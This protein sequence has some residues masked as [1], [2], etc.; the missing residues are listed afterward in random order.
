[1]NAPQRT[2]AYAPGHDAVMRLRIVAT[3]AV[4]GVGFRPFVHRLAVSEGL[5][6]FVRNTGDGAVI[7]VE[8]DALALERFVARFDTEL[9]HPAQV[10]ERRIE[11]MAACGDEAFAIAAST[12]ERTQF[13]AVLPDLATCAECLDEI[14]D[15]S[16]RRYRYPFTTCVHCGPRFSL[17]ECAPYDR[18]RTAMRRFTMCAA[19]QAEYDDPAS[20]RFHAET[21]ACRHCGPRLAL[22][23]A[24]GRPIC[25]DDDTLTQ[26]AD[27]LRAGAIVA[28]KGLGGFQLLADARNDAAVRLL[29]ERKRRPSKPFAIMA[30]DFDAAT[31]LAQVGATEAALLRSRAAPIVLLRAREDAAALAPSVAP[32]LPWLGIMLPYTPLHHLLMK[33][34]G[35]PIVATSGNRSGD[36]IVCDER[37]AIQTLHGVADLFLIHDRPIVHRVDDSVVRVVAG[38]PVVIRHAR[39]YAPLVLTTQAVD[40]RGASAVLALGGHGKSAVAAAAGQQI[41]LGPYIGDLDGSAAR[42]AFAQGTNDMQRLFPMTSPAI[43]CD[44]HPDYYSTQFAAKLANEVRRVPHHVAHVLA[45]MA[46]RGLEAQ[47][48]LGVAWDGSGYGGD[49]TVWGGEFIALER[50]HG[51]YVYRRVAHVLPFRLP[52]GEAAMR[53]PDRAAF[54]ALHAVFGE[55]MWSKHVLPPVRDAAP[56]A[57]RLFNV[58]LARGVHAPLTSSAGRLFDAVSSILGVCRH[59]SFEGEAAL[60]L[61]AAASRS[62]QAFALAPAVLRTH[63]DDDMLVA[64]WTPTLAA[65]VEASEAGID[66]ATLAAAFHDALAQLIADVV[67]QVAARAATRH[68]LLTGGCFQ[69]E[70]LASRALA[71]LRE[72]GFEAFTHGRVPPNDGG[73]AVGQALFAAAATHA[74]YAEH[75]EKR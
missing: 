22:F 17:I 63:A 37:E 41:V 5:C 64:D 33:Q 26:A 18:E 52:G 28:M 71:R 7:E 70:R 47:R 8:G 24:H 58:M 23:D 43:A 66:A 38:E 30:P 14:S 10:R 54:G 56:E 49:G 13:A 19:C 65:L 67:A 27:A 55:A 20:R 39:G 21:N 40:S 72:V 16:N 44:T 74:Q 35:F 36:P 9:R 4:Q 57:R 48:V 6:G 62:S 73:L 31:A 11:S 61:E 68:V 42:T 1:M 12:H 29:R 34:L 51:G 50:N 32:S 53:E 60:A 45:G 46:D 3:G 25:M 15:P 69:N 59:S 75:E 2:F